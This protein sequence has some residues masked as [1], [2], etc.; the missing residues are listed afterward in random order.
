MKKIVNIIL[1]VAVLALMS[2]CAEKKEVTTNDG[3]KSV[4]RTYVQYGLFDE[5]K[6]NPNIEYEV[7]IGNFIWGV[8]LCET[9]IAPIIIFGWY[10]YEP[11]GP[12]VTDPNLVGVV[13]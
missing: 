5:N 12:K 3:N 7:S 4:T 10:L 11:V 8:L 9:V 13:S 2:G 6:R 1:A